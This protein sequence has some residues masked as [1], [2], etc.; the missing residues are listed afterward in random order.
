MGI[1]YTRLCRCEF[2]ALQQKIVVLN[3]GLQGLICQPYLVMATI[4]TGM[5]YGLE[6]INDDTVE[7]FI[8]LPR[9]CHYFS[10]KR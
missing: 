9:H 4:L 3:T 2:H 1:Q 5:L 7:F 10:K 6:K 8:P